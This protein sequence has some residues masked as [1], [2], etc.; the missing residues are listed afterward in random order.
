[1]VYGKIHSKS[2]AMA[3]IISYLYFFQRVIITSTCKMWQAATLS[4]LGGLTLPEHPIGHGD[5]QGT[6]CGRS[7]RNFMKFAY[8]FAKPRLVGGDWN[9]FFIFPET[10][11]NGKIIPIEQL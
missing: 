7:V 2:M 6:W 4:W 8:S 10:V 5:T 3:S 9:I 1:M 11:G